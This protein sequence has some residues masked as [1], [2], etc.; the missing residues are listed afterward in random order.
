[1]IPRLLLE[2]QFLVYGLPCA[3]GPALHMGGSHRRWASERFRMIPPIPRWPVPIECAAPP[4][5]APMPHIRPARYRTPDPDSA[6]RRRGRDALPLGGAFRGA[7]PGGTRRP[8][9]CKWYCAW[10][11]TRSSPSTRCTGRC[12]PVIRRDQAPDST[13][14]SGSG[15]PIPSKG[16]RVASSMIRLIRRAALAGERRQIRPGLAGR[17]NGH[18][19]SFTGTGS[20]RSMRGELAPPI[21]RGPR[22]AHRLPRRPPPLG[23]T[24]LGRRPPRP[25]RWCASC[26]STPRLAARS[27]RPT[28]RTS[29][30]RP[31]AGLHPELWGVSPPRGRPGGGRPP[32]RRPAAWR[33]P[34]RRAGRRAS[35]PPGGRSTT[36]RPWTARASSGAERRCSR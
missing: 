23:L 31:A 35:A 1:M 20:R 6:P 25:A 19:S 29:M 14:L 21:L 28:P 10:R 17:H 32:R 4:G 30:S 11:I 22:P 24:H 2:C 15:F 18:R 9:T 3:E 26:H 8:L 33:A 34:H 13:C 12:S 5:P 16:W 7:R 36:S 27:R